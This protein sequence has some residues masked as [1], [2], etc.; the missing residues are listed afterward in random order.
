MEY[1]ASVME[2]EMISARNIAN[3]IF[4]Q[5][6]ERDYSDLWLF[7][8]YKNELNNRCKTFYC[9]INIR[10]LYHISHFVFVHEFC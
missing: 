9:G 3:K 10:R 8:L 4:S 7:Y 2:M 1:V 6:K 5:K